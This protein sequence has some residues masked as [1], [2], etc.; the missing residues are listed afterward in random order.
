MKAET[1]ELMRWELT[2]EGIP[3]S[4]NQR[5]NWRDKARAAKEWRTAACLKAQEAGIPA[6]ERMKVSAVVYRANLG[7]ADEDNDRSRLKAC[8]DG[9]VDAGV[10]PRD[11]RKYV[12]WGTVTEE[13]GPRGLRIIVEAV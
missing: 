7:V 13:R 5:L 10:V 8:L 12:V 2:F 4:P 1:A 3:P 11:T 6:L 9:V